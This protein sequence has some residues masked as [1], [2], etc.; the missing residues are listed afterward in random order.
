[1]LA[2]NEQ[3]ITQGT[4]EQRL[5]Y[6]GIAQIQKAYVISQMV[7]MFGDIPYSEALKGAANLAPR[8]DKDADIYNGNPG[9]GIQSLFSLIDDGIANL[10]KG[11]SVIVRNDLIYEGDLAKWARLGRTLKLKLYV[12]IR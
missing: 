11:K 10:D 12:Q 3:I 8:Y 4:A 7:D 1:M 6:V 5:S 9:L 2:N